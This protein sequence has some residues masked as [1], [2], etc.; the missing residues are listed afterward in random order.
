MRLYKN[1]V[2][3]ILVITSC[4]AHSQSKKIDTLLQK[5]ANSTNR[6]QQDESMR[7]S[8]LYEKRGEYSKALY[9]LKEYIKQKE[10]NDE[11]F[12]I[13]LAA[14]IEAQYQF[15]EKQR[16]QDKLKMDLMEAQAKSAEKS[17]IIGITMVISV[18]GIVVAALLF[19]SNKKIRKKNMLLNAQNLEIQKRNEKL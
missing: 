13:S 5:S 19:S 16:E 11:I 12:K 6:K 14:N 8:Q 10:A 15:Q 7:M 4:S 17:L 2:A 9:H 3:L 1:I 18:S